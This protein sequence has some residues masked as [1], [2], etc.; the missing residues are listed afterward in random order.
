ML[1]YKARE[2]V[3]HIQSTFEAINLKGLGLENARYLN[4][5]ELTAGERSNRMLDFLGGFELIDAEM[6]IFVLEGL[7][8]TGH[9]MHAFYEANKLNKPNDRTFKLIYNPAIRFKHR[10]Y[11]DFNCAIKVI[12]LR[13]A[14]SEIIA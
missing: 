14:L 3:N 11:L 8:G 4:T 1:P 10:L 2:A 13:D 5:K 7:G 9:S 6:R 12:K